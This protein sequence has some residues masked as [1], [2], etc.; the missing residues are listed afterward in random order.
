MEAHQQTPGCALGAVAHRMQQVNHDTRNRRRL[1][2][3][4]DTHS[5]DLRA[6]AT[7][8][9]VTRVGGEPAR[10]IRSRG[11]FSRVSIGGFS[12]SPELVTISTAVPWRPNH[13]YRPQDRGS[14]R[15]GRSRSVPGP[16]RLPGP[17]PAAITGECCSRFAAR[18]QLK[19]ERI[20]ETCRWNH[21]TALHPG[22]VTD[23]IVPG[24]R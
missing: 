24:T 1:A 4:I 18:I 13:F 10:S 23:Q 22:K 12:T 17:P 11:G 7:V 6:V 3:L 21:N 16:K 14:Y 20:K 19:K 15:P 5:F 2:E 9:C 8:P